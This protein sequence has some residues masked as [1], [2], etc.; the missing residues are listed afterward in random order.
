MYHLQVAKPNPLTSLVV[1][2]TNVYIAFVLGCFDI[3]YQLYKISAVLYISIGDVPVSPQLVYIDV[4]LLCCS[5]LLLYTDVI[6][7]DTVFHQILPALKCQT[8]G[9]LWLF[10]MQQYD[11]ALWSLHLYDI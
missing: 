8:L 5:D 7:Y 3:A 11:I 2:L 1:P 10:D 6:A 9:T 4:V